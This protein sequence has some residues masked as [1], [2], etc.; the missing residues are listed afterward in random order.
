MNTA[1]SAY[2]G[3]QAPNRALI[4][5]RVS[6]RD[7]GISGST[8][9]EASRV[10]RAR[11]GGIGNRIWHNPLYCSIYCILANGGRGSG[12]QCVCDN[13]VHVGSRLSVRQIIA[14]RVR[15]S[16]FPTRSP[17]PLSPAPTVSPRILRPP[18]SA[19]FGAKGVGSKGSRTLH[20]ASV[21]SE[22]YG[23]RLAEAAVW[24]FMPVVRHPCSSLLSPHPSL[25][26]L[27]SEN[28]TFAIFSTPPAI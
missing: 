24:S 15:A 11:A 10:L 20:W 8:P 4:Q 17:A 27:L 6:E 14:R 22:S 2:A 1:D 25:L 9:P 3:G 21:R 23:L 12:S 18:I 13:S 28:C 5:C 19:D 7:A 16:R 26:S